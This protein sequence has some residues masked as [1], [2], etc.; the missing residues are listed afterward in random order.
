M[1]PSPESPN[2]K[3][4]V[5][6]LPERPAFGPLLDELEQLV[7]K[8]LPDLTEDMT[9]EN[10]KEADFR[11]FDNPDERKD[12]PYSCETYLEHNRHREINNRATAMQYA[13]LDPALNEAISRQEFSAANQRAT[14]HE[15]LPRALQILIRILRSYEELRVGVSGPL[16]DEFL[17]KDEQ[18]KTYLSALNRAVTERIAFDN[19]QAIDGYFLPNTTGPGETI[20]I[21]ESRLRNMG[22][23]SKASQEIFLKSY[24]NPAEK[25]PAQQRQAQVLNQKIMNLLSGRINLPQKREMPVGETIEGLPKN[26]EPGKVFKDLW[27]KKYPW[28]IES[29]VEAV[30]TNPRLDQMK[31]DSDRSTVMGQFTKFAGLVSRYQFEQERLMVLQNQFDRD[32]NLE[33]A[34]PRKR[35]DQTDPR[36]KEQMTSNL[37][38]IGLAHLKWMEDTVKLMEKS[39]LTPNPKEKVMNWLESF[40]NKNGRSG[41]LKISQNLANGL[42]FYLPEIF[43]IKEHA[44]AYLLEP[45]EK[46]LGWPK[47]KE[48]WEELTPDEQKTVIEK[49]RSIS[50][51]INGFDRTALIRFR[52]TAEAVR[53]VSTQGSSADTPSVRRAEISA[54][55]ADQLDKGER[56]VAGNLT[57]MMGKYG[58][59]AVTLALMQQLE[60]D[61]GAPAANGKPGGGFMGEYEKFM[62]GVN[63]TIGIHIDVEAAKKEMQNRY[64]WLMKCLFCAAAGVFVAGAVGVSKLYRLGRGLIRSAGKGVTLAEKAAEAAI[65]SGRVVRVLG[66]V[67]IVATAADLKRVLHRNARSGPLKELESIESGIELLISGGK[68]GTVNV[69]QDEIDVLKKRLDCFVY[70]DGAIRVAQEL[71]KRRQGLDER[72]TSRLKEL[73]DTA[74]ELRRLAR[75]YKL[76]YERQFPITD[77][78]VT[79]PD[80]FP[81]NIGFNRDGVEQARE[82]G[83]KERQ[84]TRFEKEHLDML[85]GLV[86][87][88]E[89]G[90][91]EKLRSDLI[92]HDELK[93]RYEKLFEDAAEFIEN[94][95]EKPER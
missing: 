88:E 2:R 15:Y 70:E 89:V 18:I 64:Q 40:W 59:P 56:I 11:C 4:E 34:A 83:F 10:L 8:P 24:S 79:D 58:R 35:L 16:A 69:R 87:P 17:S 36:I 41:A 39:P 37:R 63:E 82:K 21:N 5:K 86:K 33:Y 46:A 42:T 44:H 9:E 53:L 31:L 26:F 78:L 50:D 65:K 1:Q 27:Q 7:G 90:E 54:E 28:L 92:S 73:Q 48:K 76:R 80:G 6:R 55:F 25:L 72:Q 84:R 93:K 85:A 67:G 75:F 77:Y 3:I 20:S 81:G 62:L 13:K 66:P 94:I 47:G 43:G 60:K 71:E 68:A 22:R 23:L 61:W 30:K 74:E 32:T 57:E 51:V 12:D 49:S 38:D 91:V 14:Y 95:E 52:E 45:V 29:Q 19:I